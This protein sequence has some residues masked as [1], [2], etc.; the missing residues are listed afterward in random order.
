MQRV[1]AVPYVKGAVPMKAPSPDGRRVATFVASGE[2][3]YCFGPVAAEVLSHMVCNSGK[4]CLTVLM[5]ISVRAGSDPIKEMNDK[6]E[7][8][9]RRA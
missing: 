2:G 3:L 9:L 4:P 5:I 1:A 7:A 8:L 6:Y